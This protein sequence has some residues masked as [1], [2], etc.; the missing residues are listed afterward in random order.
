MSAVRH[1]MQVEPH[2]LQQRIIIHLGEQRFPGLTPADCLV[3]DLSFPRN[4]LVDAFL[5]R[6]PADELV[7]QH[8]LLLADAEARSVAWFSTAGFH[9]R[10]K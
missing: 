4:H 10:S 2:E 9:Q 1:L 6:S 7:D 5:D 3:G 8:V